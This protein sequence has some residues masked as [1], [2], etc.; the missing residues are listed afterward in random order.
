MVG[1]LIR[2]FTDQK[3][4]ARIFFSFDICAST[5]SI[6]DDIFGREHNRKKKHNY[7]ALI[8]CVVEIAPCVCPI[9]FIEY[10]MIGFGDGSFKQNLSVT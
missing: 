2:I 9:L 7:K 10:C 8:Q 5:V 6:R 1:I 3:V 4:W